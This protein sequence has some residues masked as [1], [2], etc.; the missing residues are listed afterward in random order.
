MAEIP[1]GSNLLI[2]KDSEHWLCVD[3]LIDESLNERPVNKCLIEDVGNQHM[4][5]DFDTASENNWEFIGEDL[6]IDIPDEHTKR[7][8]SLFPGVKE[9]SHAA[10]VYGGECTMCG[11]QLTPDDATLDFYDGNFYCS[12]CHQEQEAVIPRDVIEC[13]DFTLKPVSFASKKFLDSVAP[14]PLLNIA[15]INPS[16]F[17]YVSEMASLRRLRR[18]LSILWSLISRCSKETSQ[19]MVTFLKHRSYMLD[20][21]ANI[22]KYSVQDL[23]DV[24][25]GI[26][27]EVIQTVIDKFAATHVN[28]CAGCLK[29]VSFCDICR[30]QY[31]PIWPYAFTNFRRCATP[32]CRRA[33][34]SDCLLKLKD[35]S[36]F[37]T[38]ELFRTIYIESNDSTAGTNS[39]TQLSMEGVELLP[40]CTACR[41]NLHIS[42][43]TNLII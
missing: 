42:K 12:N 8:A 36:K 26:L 31:R 16:L 23:L 2:N 30:D 29:W 34:H 27:E 1:T 11:S 21:V 41:S 9:V 38:A 37:S 14:C 22:D 43:L 7:L 20:S 18:T 32:G 13:W 17:S 19:D 5:E 25:N 28:S 4:P 35:E 33:M 24:P 40:H 6:K 10:S 3:R 15:L 39:E